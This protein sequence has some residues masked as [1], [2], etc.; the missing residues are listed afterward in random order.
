MS[1]FPDELIRAIRLNIKQ[2]AV[3]D[4]TPIQESAEL[5]SFIQ[6]ARDLA[7]DVERLD[8]WLKRDGVLPTDWAAEEDKPSAA[9]DPYG[10]DKHRVYEEN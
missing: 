5:F 6:H 3:E 9:Y 10:G 1:E 7:A 8:D 4:K 2:M